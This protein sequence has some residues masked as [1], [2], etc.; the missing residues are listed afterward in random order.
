MSFPKHSE[1]EL[2]L[3]KIQNSFV[4]RPQMGFFNQS[5]SADAATNAKPFPFEWVDLSRPEMEYSS[6]LTR[7]SREYDRR[8]A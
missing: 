2:P 8:F 5:R 3:L 7:V 4:F 6:L 1:I